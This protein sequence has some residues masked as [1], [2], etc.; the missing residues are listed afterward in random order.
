[1]DHWLGSIARQYLER[2]QHADKGISAGKVG[3]STHA[4]SGSESKMLRS[5]SLRD[6]QE[7]FK[8]E[9]CRGLELLNIIICS[10]CVLVC[11]N[12]LADG[13]ELFGR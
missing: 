8:K 12:S 1:M 5:R 10:P 9:F 2:D 11:G 4:R 3:P 7:S 6:V 13:V